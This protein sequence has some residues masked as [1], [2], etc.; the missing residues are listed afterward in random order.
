MFGSYQ[1]IFKGKTSQKSMEIKYNERIQQAK[2]TTKGLGRLLFL[3]TAIP[4][5][6]ALTA[7]TSLAALPVAIPILY[8]Q[9][10][11]SVK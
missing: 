7:I 5:G 4:T 9:N 11:Y 2:E 6:I 8:L 10:H 3:G 1:Y